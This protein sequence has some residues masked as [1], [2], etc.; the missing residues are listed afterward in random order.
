MVHTILACGS[1]HGAG[2]IAP[3]VIIGCLAF[4][5]I[6]SKHVKGV[7]SF[8]AAVWTSTKRADE[9]IGMAESRCSFV[10]EL[11]IS[12]GCGGIKVIGSSSFPSLVVTSAADCNLDR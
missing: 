1:C 3:S 10:C 9:D 8:T 11:D 7:L 2:A 6:P 12:S 5:H 4:S